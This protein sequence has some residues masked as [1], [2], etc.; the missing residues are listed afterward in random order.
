MRSSLSAT[1]RL[2]LN[3]DVGCN[4]MKTIFALL[5]FIATLPAI[6][7][8]TNLTAIS[9]EQIITAIS[10]DLPDIAPYIPIDSAALSG[11]YSDD[12]AFSKDRLYLFSDGT[13]MYTFQ[14]DLYPETIQEKGSWSYRN[15]RIINVPDDSLPKAL[16][17]QDHT[18]FL[19]SCHG[20]TNSELSTNIYL[21]GAK[22]NFSYLVGNIEPLPYL[23]F[24]MC[25]L[26]NREKYDASTDQAIKG[27]LMSRAWRPEE[28]IKMSIQQGGPGYPPQ[29]VGSPDP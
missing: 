25:S 2:S 26:E 23:V 15:E 14:G 3:A 10:N 17:P 6:A 1:S 7:W 11:L 19:L 13:Y 8:D 18:Y 21:L 12:T 4:K 20:T 24:R 22:D 27:D 16:I 9:T 28:I 29:S 5:I